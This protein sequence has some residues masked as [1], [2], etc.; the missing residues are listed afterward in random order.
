MWA[1]IEDGVVRELTDVDPA[2]RFHPDLVWV[3]CGEEVCQ[4]CLYQ[5]GKFSAPAEPSPAPA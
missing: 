4:G 2:G 3:E 1:R 5:G